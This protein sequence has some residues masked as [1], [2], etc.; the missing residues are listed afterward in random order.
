MIGDHLVINVCTNKVFEERVLFL[1]LIDAGV[2][3]TFL[4]IGYLRRF[5]EAHYTQHMIFVSS[6]LQC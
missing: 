4:Y 2:C 5:D 1:S 3:S 6:L